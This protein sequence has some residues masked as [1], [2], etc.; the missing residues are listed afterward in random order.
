M[1][2]KEGLTRFCCKNMVISSVELV[3]TNLR[4]LN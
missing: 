2:M 4:N 1:Y 3:Q